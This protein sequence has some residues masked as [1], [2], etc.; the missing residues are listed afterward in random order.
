MDL[1][2]PERIVVGEPDKWW[3]QPMPAGLSWFGKNWYPRCVLGGMLPPF[4]P[5]QRLV[6]EVALGLISENHVTSAQKRE[7]DATI[8]PA[9]FNGASPG[10]AV[11][12]LRGDE[13]VR[14]L[15]LDPSG[16]VSFQLPGMR[17]RFSIAFQNKHLKPRIHIHTVWIQKDLDKVSIIWSANARPPQMLPLTLP[18]RER[19]VVDELEGVEIR[20]DGQE[21]VHEPIDLGK[22]PI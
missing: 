5:N 2:T 12:R 20:V 3:H 16:D 22:V 17:P 10:L 1:L 4:P 19:P 7:M 14:L 21:V 11:P 9:F 15:G 8:E 13:P 6:E 18:T